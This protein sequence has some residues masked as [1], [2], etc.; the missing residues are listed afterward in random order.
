MLENWSQASEEEEKFVQKQAKWLLAFSALA[1][2]CI[3]PVAALGIW[4]AHDIY[5]IYVDSGISLGFLIT[6]IACGVVIFLALLLFWDF[7]KHYRGVTQGMLYRSNE[8]RVEKTWQEKNGKSVTEYFSFVYKD[9][10]TGEIKEHK[11]MNYGKKV[12]EGD[13]LCVLA[14]KKEDSFEIIEVFKENT[15]KKLD[16]SWIFLDG[17]VLA[18]MFFAWV[19]LYL[20]FGA[21]AIYIRWCI[22][23]ALIAVVVLTLF[24]GIVEK[25][26][27]AIVASLLLCGF[28]LLI[29]MPGSLKNIVSDMAEGPQKITVYGNLIETQNTVR[30]RRGRRRN[31]RHYKLDVISKETDIGEVELTETAYDYYKQLYGSTS[32]KGQLIY[33]SHSKIF[34]YLLK[35][36]EDL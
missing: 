30:G 22:N 34:L 23:I 16:A 17:A 33:Y 10:V 21:A 24:Y 27:S 29:G 25:K 2:S 15:E 6:S 36:D 28:F 8:G 3:L 14:Y 19:F 9:L 13:S 5:A 12:K 20:D 31:V 35:E 18:A 32:V 4:Q 7:W 11:H 26:V 1:C